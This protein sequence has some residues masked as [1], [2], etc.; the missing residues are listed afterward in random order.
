MKTAI[1][2]EK[3]KL[4]YEHWK[5]FMRYKQNYLEIYL[6]IFRNLFEFLEEK[7]QIPAP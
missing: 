4:T 1:K 6:L 7:G 2:N 5:M 3:E